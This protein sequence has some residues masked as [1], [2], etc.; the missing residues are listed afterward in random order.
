MVT[1]EGVFVNLVEIQTIFNP[2]GSV[3]DFIWL[4]MSPRI[5]RAISRAKVLYERFFCVKMGRCLAKIIKCSDENGIAPL[6]YNEP[7]F[8]VER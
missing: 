7:G 8:G 4:K 6:S 1:A 5:P 2:K 3:V